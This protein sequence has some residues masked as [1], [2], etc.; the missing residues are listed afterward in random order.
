MHTKHRLRMVLG[1][2]VLVL[3]LALPRAHADDFWRIVVVDEGEVGSYSSLAILPSGQPAISYY[4]RGNGDL[5]YTWF[6]GTAWHTS[7]VDSDG[8]VGGHTSVAILPSGQPAIC[9]FD[10]TNFA[11]KYAWYDVADWHVTTVDDGDAGTWSAGRYGSLVILP[12]GQPAI[13]YCAGN[14]L[15][16]AVFDG[17]G[18]QTT[19]VDS[20]AAASSLAV[21][22]SGQPAIAYADHT[23]YSLKYAWFDGVQWHP[24]TVD[25]NADALLWLSLTIL[26]SGH[27]AI[28][29]RDYEPA[30]YGEWLK[31]AWFD[32][33]AWLTEIVDGG[34]KYTAYVSLDVQSSGHPAL[35]CQGDEEHLQYVWFDGDWH[36]STIDS[37]PDGPKKWTSLALLPSGNPSIS[38]FDQANGE[39]RYAFVVDTGDMNCDRILNAYDI[40]PFICA[41]SPNCDYATEYPE[42]AES[43]ADCNSDGTVNAYDIDAF[44]ALLARD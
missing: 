37:H 25:P 21:L 16:Y 4:D 20:H 10:F 31:Y 30:D 40:D 7:T 14:H 19:I 9:Y 42:C 12:S 17:I 22:P 35:S 32:G 28:C 36:V 34:S 26:P 2:V 41:L 13:S 39:L 33:T 38:Y 44:L 5:K 1:S 27:P 29:Y 11:L 24:T 3:G 8:N 43:L 18:W 6:E 23:D 15:M